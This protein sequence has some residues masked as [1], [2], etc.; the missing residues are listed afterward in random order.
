MKEIRQGFGYDEIIKRETDKQRC[1]TAIRDSL[2]SVDDRRTLCAINEALELHR[3]LPDVE[4]SMLG[5]SEY[6]FFYTLVEAFYTKLQEAEGSKNEVAAL[7]KKFRSCCHMLY[8]NDVIPDVKALSSWTALS[9]GTM[10]N[11]FM[12][13]VLNANQHYVHLEEG[14][15]PSADNNNLANCPYPLYMPYLEY[16]PEQRVLFDEFVHYMS[17]VQEMEKHGRD[18]GRIMETYMYSKIK[19]EAAAARLNADESIVLERAELDE[20]NVRLARFF[21]YYSS[22]FR[23]MHSERQIA[24][25]DP[26]YARFIKTEEK[27]TGVVAVPDSITDHS[28]LYGFDLRR[29]VPSHIYAARIRKGLRNV[30]REEALAYLRTGFALFS[31]ICIPALGALGL[32]EKLRLVDEYYSFKR[33]LFHIGEKSVRL[34][35][36]SELA[37]IRLPSYAKLTLEDIDGYAFYDGNSD[38]ESINENTAGQDEKNTEEKG[39]R[40]RWLYQVYLLLSGYF[41]MTPGSEGETNLLQKGH[42]DDD[43]LMK[44]LDFDPDPAPYEGPSL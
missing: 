7:V 9:T 31:P 21:D 4:Y 40:F 25:D 3:S 37:G 17:Y 16:T 42:S 10:K 35:S 26:S 36:V 34:K 2:A 8:S 29:K 33:S 32:E 41:E 14:L 15:T 1:F 28:N 23:Y 18:I 38:R 5:G 6:G 39:G 43:M 11:P 12:F 24:E 44:V 22:C 13:D 19:E 27:N 30:S 20:M